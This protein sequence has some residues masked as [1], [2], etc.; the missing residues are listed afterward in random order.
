M[1][2]NHLKHHPEF[3]PDKDYP[4]AQRAAKKLISTIMQTYAA[5]I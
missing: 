4:V 1:F 2:E 5:A 3:K